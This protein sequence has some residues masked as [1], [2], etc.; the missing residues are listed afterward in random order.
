[1]KNVHLRPTVLATWNVSK[2]IASEKQEKQW[3]N[4]PLRS[5]EEVSLSQLFSVSACFNVQYNTINMLILLY[6]R[7]QILALSI[8]VSKFIS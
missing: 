8:Q 5:A 6:L 4:L 7:S 1:M 3:E 2:V